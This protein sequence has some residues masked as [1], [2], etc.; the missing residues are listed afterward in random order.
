MTTLYYFS[1]TGNSLWFTKLLAE[2]LNAKVVSIAASMSSD[3]ELEA[4]DV[5]GIIFPIYMYRPPHIV[6]EFLKK[7]K[8]PQYLFFV[9]NYG[10]DMGD[11]VNNTQKYLKD[12]GLHE[13]AYFNV[14]LPDN[15]LP[16]GEPPEKEEQDK[17]FEDAEA[18]LELI[19]DKVSLKQSYND[20]NSYSWFKTKVY[21]G[22]WYA[23]GY[24]AIT[25]SAANFRT[26]DKC[27]GCKSCQ[28]VCPVENIKMENGRPV[29]G[30][31]CEQCLA[32]INWCKKEAIELGKKTEGL[33]RYHNPFIKRK[34][35][36]A[37]KK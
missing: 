18:K 10:G 21:P 11:G 25:R 34:E 13:D 1:G 35:I 2:R 20:E 26:T 12:A 30:E 7:L 3:K 8:Q 19:C 9:A 22:K 5:A 33:T 15:Y 16:F 32:C 37:Q 23:L 4:D 31:K 6:V 17:Q 24:W 29:W 28:K 36:I 27:V 14:K